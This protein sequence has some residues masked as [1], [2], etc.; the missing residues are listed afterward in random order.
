M[1]ASRTYNYNSVLSEPSQPKCP[2][3][4]PPQPLPRRII[5]PH[6]LLSQLILPEPIRTAGPRP[7]PMMPV[8][9][10]ENLL[11][12]QRRNGAEQ[13]VRVETLLFSQ[14]FVEVR[15][16]DPV[17]E[18]LF[19]LFLGFRVFVVTVGGDIFEVDVIAVGE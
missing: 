18:V 2:A 8:L 3:P 16:E 14:P 13:Y 1:H 6:L 9:I 7:K 17:R 12:D 11:H 10:L 4:F 5:H 19:L 15:G